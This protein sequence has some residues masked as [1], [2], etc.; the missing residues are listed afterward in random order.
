[1]LASINK[2]ELTDTN[3]RKFHKVFYP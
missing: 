1:M 2:P 3:K